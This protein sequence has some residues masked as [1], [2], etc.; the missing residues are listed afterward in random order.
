MDQQ[1]VVQYRQTYI[2]T[3]QTSIELDDIIKANSMHI[4]NQANFSD[5]ISE[6][7]CVKVNNKD[8]LH[9]FKTI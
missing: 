7:E 9:A 5:D 8:V 4:T 3:D 1:F 2:C 6:E